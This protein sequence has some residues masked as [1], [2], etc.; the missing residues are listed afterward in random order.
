MIHTTVRAMLSIALGMF[1][2]AVT[3]VNAADEANASLLEPRADAATVVVKQGDVEVTLGDVDTWMLDVPEKDRSG[4]IRDSERIEQMLFQMLVMKQANR[5]ARASGLDKK[6]YVAAHMAIASER[7]LARYQM[8]AAKNAIKPPDFS[9]LAKEKYTADP[10]QFS[11]PDTATLVH[12]LITE[13]E[14]GSDAAV[15]L[16]QKLHKRV[17]KNP[18]KLQALVMEYSD[19]PSKSTNQGTL[20]NI[21]LATLD[22]DFADAARKL[23]PGQLSQPVKSQFGWHIIRLDAIT[24]GRQPEFDEIKAKIVSDLEQEYVDRTFRAYV[25]ELRQRPLDPVPEVLANLPF[26]YGGKPEAMAPTAPAPAVPEAKQ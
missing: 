13:G 11:E 5:D 19:D 4:F 10:T 25:D 9:E 20:K 8:E 7:T 18:G 23:E 1:F 6:P 17:L 2:V 12:L 21:S 16:I 26:R 14:R 22:P 15:K 3:T 24:R